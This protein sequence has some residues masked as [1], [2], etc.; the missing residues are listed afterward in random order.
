MGCDV[1]AY[2][3]DAEGAAGAVDPSGRCTVL[4]RCAELKCESLLK[5]RFS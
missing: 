3:A 2:S 1:A 4:R 5:I